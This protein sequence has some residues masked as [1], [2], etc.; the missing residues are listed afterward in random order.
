VICRLTGSK[1]QS[2]IGL[3]PWKNNKNLIIAKVNKDVYVHVRE[4]KIY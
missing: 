3:K 4:I 2:I 1:A